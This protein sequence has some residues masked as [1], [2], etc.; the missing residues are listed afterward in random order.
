[1]P[2][3]RLPDVGFIGLGNM[4]LPMAG[5][6]IDAGHEVRGFD[7]SDS[8][9][10]EFAARG[11]KAAGSA[12]EAARDAG[13][14]ILMLPD[15]NVVEAVATSPSFVAALTA[16]SS[17]GAASPGAVVVD[18]SSSEPERTRQLAHFLREHGARL[19]D[20]PVSGG[21]KGAVSGRLAVM[22]GGDDEDV[23]RVED[24]LASLGKI[25]RAGPVGAGHAVK[26][27]NNL[28]SATHLLVTSEAMLAGQRF[29]IE[30]DV[31]LAIFNA[32]SGRSGSTENKWPNFILPETYDS[33]F[34]LRLML[35]DMRIA[36]GLA[37][38]MGSPS[39]LGEQAAAMWAKAADDLPAA[40]DHTEIARW[41]RDSQLGRL[42]VGRLPPKGTVAT[43]GLS[44]PREL[45]GM[46]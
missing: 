42:P 35:K 3:V 2:D 26:A 46:P 7:V 40:A 6:L 43:A 22:V 1:M 9:R 25:Y 28:M 11:G 39:R 34:G 20:A 38:Q 44:I 32:S 21:V 33:G 37:G 15:S 31:M 19:V 13:L 24:V 10:A 30:P 16:T 17:P 18:M 12:A 5:R 36:T 27:L 8:A 14:V 45:R 41:L 29:G 4:G 23:R